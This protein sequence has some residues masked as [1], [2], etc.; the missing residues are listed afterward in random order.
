MLLASTIVLYVIKRNVCVSHELIWTNLQPYYILVSILFIVP[1]VNL[2]LF[3]KSF[4]SN[5]KIQYLAGKSCKTWEFQVQNT[6]LS[7]SANIKS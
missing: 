4:K 7:S 1:F 2:I 3:D 6:Q 5:Q